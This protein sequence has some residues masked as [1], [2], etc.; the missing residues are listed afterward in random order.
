MSRK[1]KIYEPYAAAPRDHLRTRHL[2]PSVLVGRKFAWDAA[3]RF[4]RRECRVSMVVLSR[5]A[6]MKSLKFAEKATVRSQ[7]PLI[8]GRQM[9]SLWKSISKG[10]V[11]VLAFVDPDV[12]DPLRRVDLGFISGR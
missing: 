11:S 9:E 10:V 8:S 6:R 3:R 7:Q 5:L 4:L 12:W 2:E 1:R